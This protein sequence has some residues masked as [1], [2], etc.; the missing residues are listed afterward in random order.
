MGNYNGVTGAHRSLF[1]PEGEEPILDEDGIHIEECYPDDFTGDLVITYQSHIRC[2][3]Y[4]QTLTGGGYIE[5]QR[6][7]RLDDPDSHWF[8]IPIKASKSWNNFAD[9]LPEWDDP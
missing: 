3:T 2:E 6:S 9:S 7:V 5:I 1:T 4:R 8:Q